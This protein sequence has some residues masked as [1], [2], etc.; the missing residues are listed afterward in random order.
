MRTSRRALLLL[1][2]CAATL[3]SQAQS[4]QKLRDEVQ[5]AITRGVS[6][7]KAQQNAEDGYWTTPQEPAFPGREALR[8]P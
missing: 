4:P 8:R 5:A 2:L 1:T 3:P 7:L 6:F